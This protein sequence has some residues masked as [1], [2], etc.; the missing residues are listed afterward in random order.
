MY[1]DFVASLCYW[2]RCILCYSSPNSNRVTF[3][4][5]PSISLTIHQP[6]FLTFPHSVTRLSPLSHTLPFLHYSPPLFSILPSSHRVLL[7]SSSTTPLYLSPFPYLS[8]H[9][10]TAMCVCV[11]GEA[12]RGEVRRDTMPPPPPSPPETFP[13]LPYFSKSA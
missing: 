2:F 3:S 9:L 13:H 11:C 8:F 5:L 12:R 4:H 7:Y 1:E 10:P 6:P